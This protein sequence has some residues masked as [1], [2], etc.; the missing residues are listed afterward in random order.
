[1]GG[2]KFDFLRNLIVE[3]TVLIKTD[4][5]WIWQADL[6]AKFYYHDDYWL[7]LSGRTDGTLITILGFRNDGLFMG[8][9]FDLSFS[10]IQRFNYGTHEITISYKFGDNARRYRWLRRY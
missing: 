2:H 10:E 1:M 3:P 5:S 9:A 7:G 4:Q 8:Y 6:G